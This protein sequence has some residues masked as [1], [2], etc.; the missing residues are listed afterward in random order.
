VDRIV[1][2][3]QAGEDVEGYCR[4]VG[5]DEI[6]GN[7]FNL[8]IALY[9]RDI[10]TKDEGDLREAVADLREAEAS[11]DEAMQRLWGHLEELGLDE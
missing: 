6:V 11:R 2:A 3:F 7:G 4:T 1:A 8:S 10:E 9:V 5:L